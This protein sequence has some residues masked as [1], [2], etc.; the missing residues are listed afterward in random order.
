MR[1]LITKPSIPARD[2]LRSNLA[3]TS[4]SIWSRSCA[5]STSRIMRFCASR[6]ATRPIRR[7]CSVETSGAGRMARSG[8]L[9]TSDTPSTMKPVFPPPS[10]STRMRSAADRFLRRDLEPAAQ[11]DDRHHD[12][13]QVHHAVD[14]GRAPWAGA[15]CARAAAR[16]RRPPRSAVRIPDRRGGR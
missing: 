6:F 9:M 10:A 16:S 15:R 4:A 7:I 5:G 14:E 11:I 8:I 2:W 3:S 13:A 1:S 12:A